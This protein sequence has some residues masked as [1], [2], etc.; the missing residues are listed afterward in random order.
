MQVDVHAH[1]GLDQERKR[2][3][4]HLYLASDLLSRASQ[5]RDL[6]RALWYRAALEALSDAL[7]IEP[8][9]SDLLN[10]YAY[11]YRSWK[12][13]ETYASARGQPAVPEKQLLAFAHNAE[14]FA[15]RAV[16]LGEHTRNTTEL[17]LVHSTLGEVLLAR[18]RPHEAIDWL[19]RALE[20]A[21]DHPVFDE[22]RWDLIE[23]YH[24]AQ[25]E[26]LRWNQDALGLAAGYAR[27]ADARAQEIFLRESLRE[28]RPFLSALASGAAPVCASEPDAAAPTFTAVMNQAA[29]N[30]CGSR[31]E[32]S[33]AA[34]AVEPQLRVRITGRG[35][36]ASL[37]LDG[38]VVQQY[39]LN[40]RAVDSHAQYRVRLM[41][42]DEP[43]SSWIPLDTHVDANGCA[44]H[45]PQVKFTRARPTRLE[46]TDRRLTL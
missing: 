24:C 20:L 12:L 16:D 25:R 33:L 5:I 39:L 31:L 11:A 41:R 3:S 26:E 23:A 44:T 43:V 29:A 1:D 27:Q 4:A 2:A 19:L 7:R 17:A 15:R 13:V 32:F 28:A 18:G 6:S 46:K 34:D 40:G 30:S 14:L 8:Y 35:S 10:G 37:P 36:D 38:S 45:T 22:I 21:P 42:D 9:N